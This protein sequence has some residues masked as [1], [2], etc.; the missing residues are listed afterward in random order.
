MTSSF[1]I[2]QSRLAKLEAEFGSENPFVIYLKMEFDAMQ[3]H[4]QNSV[5]RIEMM[6]ASTIAQIVDKFDGEG[7]SFS[8]VERAVR[9]VNA[10]HHSGA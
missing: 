1:E 3:R 9:A 10:L 2:F 8:E 4:N 7:P 6:P 5:G